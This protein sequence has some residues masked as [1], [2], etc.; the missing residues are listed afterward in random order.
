VYKIRLIGEYAKS[1]RWKRHVKTF[2]MLV[3][4]GVAGELLADGGIFLF[5]SHLQTIAD[6]EIAD[7]TLTAG[8]AKAS[9]EN[10]AKAADRAKASADEARHKADAAGDAAGDAATKGAEVGRKADG[11]LQKYV[12]TENKLEE[13]RK[14]LAEYESKNAPRRVSSEQ[15]ELIK[16]RLLR[17]KVWS[18]SVFATSTNSPEVIDFAND[19]EA[20]FRSASLK[21]EASSSVFTAMSPGTP[22]RGLLVKISSNRVADADILAGALHDAGLTGPGNLIPITKSPSSDPN[23]LQVMVLPK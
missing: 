2:E 19:L 1:E 7:L 20:V 12:D 15:A 3:I 6:Q 22:P 21:V 14:I 23:E 5:S 13:Q 18:I 17:F 9:A 4:I 8:N 16:G 11:L 10:A